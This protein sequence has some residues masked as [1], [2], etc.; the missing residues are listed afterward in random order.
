FIVTRIPCHAP[1]NGP[2]EPAA[3][4]SMGR[5]EPLTTEQ[6]TICVGPDCV[7]TFQEDPNDGFDPVRNRLR[8]GN[9]HLRAW[10][11]DYLAYALLDAAIDAYFPLLEAYGERVEELEAKVVECPEQG[12]IREIHDLKRDLLTARRAIW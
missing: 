3:A 12:H 1:K 10:T 7:I 5:A 11:P 2:A 8:S 6:V 9:G 4:P